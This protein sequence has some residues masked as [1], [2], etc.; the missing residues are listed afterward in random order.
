MLY[1]GQ[2]LRSGEPDIAHV[3]DVEDAD[4][5]TNRVVLGHDAADGRVFNGHVPAVEFDHFR[6]HLAM[7]RVKRGLAN[8]WRSRLDCGQ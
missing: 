4:A 2:R 3:A 7:H 1:R 8:S 6:A 5:S